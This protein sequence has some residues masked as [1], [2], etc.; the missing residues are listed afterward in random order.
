MGIP[1]ESSLDRTAAG[2]VSIVSGSGDLEI[3]MYMVNFI[4]NEYLGHRGG[5]LYIFIY[6]RGNIDIIIQECQF[7]SNKSPGHGAAMFV[8]SEYSDIES[9]N[10]QIVNTHFNQ[11]IA[12]SSIVY[13][14]QVGFKQGYY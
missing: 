9:N 4:S 12:G 3:N 1:Y 8:Y 14:T 7:I 2:A 5:A 10:M 11:N 6:D 13:I